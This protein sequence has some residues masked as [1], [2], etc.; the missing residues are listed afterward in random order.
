VVL[1]AGR[2]LIPFYRGEALSPGNKIPGPAVV[3][4]TDTTILIGRRDRVEVDR[5]QNLIIAVGRTGI[6]ERIGGKE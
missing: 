2:E 5:Y 6:I 4:R 1:D 3:L